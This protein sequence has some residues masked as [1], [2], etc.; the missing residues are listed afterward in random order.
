MP[1]QANHSHAAV[2]EEA[3]TRFV[4]E[5]QQG[6]EPCVDRFIEQYPQCKAQLEVR[7]R[8]LA[9]VDSLFDSL[10]RA[11][12]TEF[13]AL[14]SEHDLSGQK[15]GSF[16]ILERIGRGGMGV[17]YLA[18]DTKL[19]RSVALKS[20]PVALQTD[21]TA[22]MRFRREAELLASL[23][24]PNIAAIHDIIEEGES[25]GHLVLEY[26]PGETLAQ[27][28]D[29]TPLNLEEVLSVGRQIAD[30]VSAAHKKGIVHRDLKPGNIKITP[31]NRVKVLDFGLAKV[32]LPEAHTM[33]TADTQAGRV[34]GT[35][36]YMSPEQARGKSVDHRTD[37]WSFGCILYEMLTGNVPFEGE[38]ATDTVAKILEREPDWQALPRGTPAKMRTLLHR[39]LEKNPNRRQRDIG[40]AA[41]EMT[42]ALASPAIAAATG[43]AEIGPGEVD[44]LAVLPLKNLTGD[45]KQ[46]YLADSITDVL[47]SDLGKIALQRVRVISL[48]TMMQYKGSNKSL[49]DITR[50]LNADAIV[51]GS[52]LGVDKSLRITVRL[53]R[54]VPEQLLWCERFDREF[55]KILML[56]GEVAHSIARQLGIAPTLEQGSL[57]AP[58][59]SVNP[60]TLKAYLLGMFHLNK[61][62]PEGARKGLAYLHQ[63]IEKDPADPLAY[64]GLA[65][66]Y[67]ASAHG[68][69]APADALEH[70]ERAALKALELDAMLAE[71]HAALAHIKLYRDWDWEAAGQTFQRALQLNPSLTMTRTHYAFFLL[72]VERVDDGLAELR[73][74]Q[75]LDPLTPYWPAC[76]SWQYWWVGDY[77]RAI[78][79]AAK[80]LELYPEFAV[81]L[82]VLGNAYAEKGMYEEAVK[83]HQR[84]AALSREW[85]WG[86]GRTYAMAGRQD[87]ARAMLAEVESEF[88]TWDTWFIAE[89]Y[90]ALGER[91]KAFRW[92][93]TAFGPPN[94]PYVPWIRFSPALKP[95][96]NDARFLELLRRLNLPK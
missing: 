9:E 76:Q 43:A 41:V 23:N 25:A 63:A 59:R 7:L 87:E 74:V 52:V 70:A 95:L 35:P 50:E 64:G 27:R 47:I 10:L 4:D 53:I 3:L 77:D 38:T 45:S 22:R 93:K 12:D 90:A 42:E 65:L 49:P 51:E 24:H 33:E 69:G 40:A 16:E 20:M 55:G 1:A 60:E 92:L 37:I 75:Q 13:S 67:A 14:E 91:D 29:R 2:L 68:P 31:E 58:P 66:G 30:A 8:D 96:Q 62:T 78:D 88:T 18:R 86:L 82:Y 34:I 73:R 72:L 5:C 84:A 39:C 48:Q 28:I 94:H 11:D 57:Q 21:A 56:S 80:S 71:A 61:S 54:A 17:V 44:S 6:A 81:G 15:L 46:E 89:I 32:T 36:A 83:V 26:V 19:K 79:E 85:K